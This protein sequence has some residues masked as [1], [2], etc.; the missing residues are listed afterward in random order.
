MV[1]GAAG[2]LF[3]V[4]VGPIRA[5]GRFHVASQKLTV[6]RINDVSRGS[7]RSMRG[8]IKACGSHG[9]GVKA[10]IAL[11]HGKLIFVGIHTKSLNCVIF[12]PIGVAGKAV[13]A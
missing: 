5:G 6:R 1:R 10:W 2:G 3:W 7:H 12:V 9:V 13:G 4:G 11:V 8:V